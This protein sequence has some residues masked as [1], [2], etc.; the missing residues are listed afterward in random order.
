M[1]IALFYLTSG[2][3]V[4]TCGF[5][6]IT[7]TYA[8]RPQLKAIYAS[9]GIISAIFG[10]YQF[11]SGL[12]FSTKE[13]E[14]SVIMLR[15]QTDLVF[16]L[17]P[18]FYLFIA[19]Y[20]QQKFWQFGLLILSCLCV[21]LIILNHQEI[22]TMRFADTNKIQL[23]EFSNFAQTDLYK[24]IG[25]TG[26]HRWLIGAVS[27][28]FCLWSILRCFIAW[29]H[30][31]KVFSAIVTL[32]ILLLFYSSYWGQ[33]IDHS[34]NNNVYIA[35][36]VGCFMLLTLSLVVAFDSSK[37][38]S[39]LKQ[40]QIEL[41]KTNAAKDVIS[42]EHEK[43]S[44]VF[45]Q[46]P[47]ATLLVD[48]QGKVE[49]H[50]RNAEMLWQSS[51]FSNLNVFDFLEEL[52]VKDNIL[53]LISIQDLVKLGPFNITPSSQIKHLS[54]TRS[55]WFQLNLFALNRDK[56]N[57]SRFVLRL[58]NV[59]DKMYVENALNFIAAEA[60]H[61]TAEQL[62]I[63]MVQNLSRIISSTYV[64]IAL[65]KQNNLETLAVCVNGNITP[66][67]S[68]K[69]HNTPSEAVFSNRVISFPNHLK[70][71]FS[72]ND[73]LQKLDVD[74]YIG[75]PITVDSKV[76]GV[77]A[78][79]NSL[80]FCSVSYLNQVMTI[81]ANRVSSE[82]KRYQTEEKIKKMAYEDYLTHLPNR[83]VAH[84]KIQDALNHEKTV[85][86]LLLDLDQFKTIN[87]ALGH[88]LGDEVIRTIGNRLR[89][90]RPLNE[91]IARIG[92][93]EFVVIFDTPPSNSTTFIEK[94]A[95]EI[96]ELIH[97]EID[98]G[99]HMLEMTATIGV[100]LLPDNASTD[101]D[102]FRVAEIVLN[103]AKQNNRGRFLIYQP[104]MDEE[105]SEKLN[106]TTGLRQALSNNEFELYYQAQ[107]NQAEQIVG[108]EALIRWIHPEKGMIPPFKFIPIAEETGLI[109]QIGDWVLKT[110]F[111]FLANN[112][113]FRGNLSL[114]VS[115]WQ[116]A[117]P[118]FVPSM[119]AMISEAQIDVTQITLEVTESAVLTDI[120][121]TIKKLSE[122]R[123]LGIK[124]ALDDFGT[125]YSSLAY[126]KNLPLDIL[127]IDKTFIDELETN[128]RPPLLESML[129]IGH[130]MGLKVV[131][132]GV[133]TQLQLAR[134]IQMKCPV[135]Q[136]YYFAKPVPK[137][138]FLTLINQEKAIS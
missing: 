16:L 11:T 93:D 24:V 10:A 28:L 97:Q 42:L 122:I 12:Y 5:M 71:S 95:N 136:G 56:E 135:F 1:L 129:S 84:E 20:S 63:Q 59:T 74:S 57:L 130:H 49:Q 72:Q 118:D 78:A 80:P 128:D 68:F 29:Q 32:F 116:F 99:D 107:Y 105:V 62:A 46:A 64:Y 58:E 34:L 37:K 111:E 3:M 121:E 38:R 66:N 91:F 30:G 92:G 31:R 67:I 55:E 125:G 133:E 39:Q 115:A 102:A 87:D 15:L 18:A 76:I 123:S 112:P 126:L 90:N 86:L 22:Y 17:L 8:Q 104:Q 138:E 70:Q 106:I 109:N 103:K 36:F 119:L 108:A 44:Q 41:Q 48:I 100:V 50:N 75:A 45:M 89:Q 61:S 65:K 110:G 2:L 47:V 33:L 51:D 25:D 114:N 52:G 132:E 81:F 26:Q 54:V 23:V 14:S 113:N 101:L 7:A 85:A 131:A 27:G 60:H 88:D 137:A 98:I 43:L 35:G 83:A 94:I 13:L 127:K 73:E 21:F 124:V 69:L 4:A 6:F 79:M 96:N 77:I 9:I 120:T 82:M 53:E 19:L 117:R 40:S 134:L